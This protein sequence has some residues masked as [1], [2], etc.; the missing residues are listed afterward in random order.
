PSTTRR[1]MRQ[2]QRHRAIRATGG[3]PRRGRA[4]SDRQ[5][6]T[7]PFPARRRA[8]LCGSV[9]LSGVGDT[10]PALGAGRNEQATSS[11]TRRERRRATAYT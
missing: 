7:P 1:V 11:A 5:E 10:G 9:G 3:A 6:V 4:A 2:F 8:R